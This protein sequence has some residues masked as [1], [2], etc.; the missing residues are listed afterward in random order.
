MGRQTPF[1]GIIVRSI[2][3]S[4]GGGGRS[5]EFDEGLPEDIPTERIQSLINELR[6]FGDPRV[7]SKITYKLYVASLNPILAKAKTRSFVR[8]KNP[9]EPQTIDVSEP[10]IDKGIGPLDNGRDVYRVEATISK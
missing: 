8:L 7:S 5:I 6:V 3:A 2:H 4:A 10:V 1:P 9:F